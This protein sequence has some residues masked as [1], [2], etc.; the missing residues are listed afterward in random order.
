MSHIESIIIALKAAIMA[1]IMQ[2]FGIYS[3][4]TLIAFVAAACRLAYS[5]EPASIKYFWRFFVMSLSLTMLMVHIGKW[6]GF[7]PEAVII[8]SGVAA[9]MAR[10]A[11]ELALHSK[12]IIAKMILARFK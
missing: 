8:I 5:K 6:R 1:A 4:A 12:G 3:G 2:T 9:F 7:D 10:E 11:L